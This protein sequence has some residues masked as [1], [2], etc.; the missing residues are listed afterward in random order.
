MEQFIL[1]LQFIY[2]TLIFN[3]YT[4][5]NSNK[6]NYYQSLAGRVFRVVN[7]AQYDCASFSKIRPK[8][9]NFKNKLSCFENYILAKFGFFIYD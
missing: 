9:G 7:L 5:N 8:L 4:N 1:I 3:Y 2:I 6:L